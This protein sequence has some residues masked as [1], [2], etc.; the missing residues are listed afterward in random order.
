M[1]EPSKYKPVSLG[2]RKYPPSA[3]NTPKI[4][5]Q[6]KKKMETLKIQPA[7][8]NTTAQ[9]QKKLLLLGIQKAGTLL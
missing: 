5:A 6:S 1:T 2:F 8:T 9:S 7:T 3:S 4:D